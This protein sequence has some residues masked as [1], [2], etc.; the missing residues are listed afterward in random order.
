M[1]QH[2]HK[3]PQSAASDKAKTLG[4]I[5]PVALLCIGFLVGLCWFARPAVSE[6]EKRELTKFP[7]LTASDF[8]SG[9]F[10]DG[11]SVWYADTFP[12]REGLIKAYH[13]VQSLFGLRGEQYQG[14]YP[15][16]NNMYTS[17]ERLQCGHGPRLPPPH[18]ASSRSSGM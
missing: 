5:L 18:G 9:R 6:S 11:I 1:N 12:G 2:E 14:R 16:H 10:T 17:T 15:L 8:L 3:T 13:G 4:L 7:K